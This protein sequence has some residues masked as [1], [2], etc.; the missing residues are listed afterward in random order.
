[1]RFA[2]ETEAGESY[3]CE[4]DFVGKNLNA[5]QG[6]GMCEQGADEIEV[7]G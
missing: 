1:M 4:P 2:N 7:D 6:C 5:V 3:A